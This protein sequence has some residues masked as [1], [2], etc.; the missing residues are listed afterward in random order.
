MD[1]ATDIHVW[2]DLRL[3]IDLIK[4]PTR[5]KGSTANKISP[6]CGIVQIRLALK[7]SRKKV[8]LNLWN[9]FY[10]LNNLFNLVNLSVLNDTNIFYNNKHHIL[11]NKIS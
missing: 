4:N 8:I 7:N 1:N 11:Y 3:M 2:N 9:I 5:V 6:G 10:L